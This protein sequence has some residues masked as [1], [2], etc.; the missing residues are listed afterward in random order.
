MK[1]APARFVA[2]SLT[3]TEYQAL[4]HATED[5]AAWVKTQIDGLL[6]R[7][8]LSHVR[9]QHPDEPAVPAWSYSLPV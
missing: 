8:G 7:R 2:V 4:R 3:E 1:H 5:P 9:E 6:D